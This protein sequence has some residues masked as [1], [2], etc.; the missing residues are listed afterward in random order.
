M[1]AST[2]GLLFFGAVSDDFAA[3]QEMEEQHGRAARKQG[4]RFGTLA[5][6]ETTG[7]YLAVV[8]SLVE[9]NAGEAKALKATQFIPPWQWKEKLETFTGEVGLSLQPG[10]PTWYVACETDRDY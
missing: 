3:W 10:E 1:S 4:L 6:G 8:A 9:V 2:Q 5:D 7:F